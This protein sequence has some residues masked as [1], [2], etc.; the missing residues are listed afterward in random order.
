MTLRAN[1]K[2]I[3]FALAASEAEKIGFRQY[4]LSASAGETKKFW[5]STN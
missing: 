5:A 4:D 1:I 2:T 3:Y